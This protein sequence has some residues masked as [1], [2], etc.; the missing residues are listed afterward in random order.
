MRVKIVLLTNLDKIRLSP[1]NRDQVILTTSQPVYTSFQPM[2]KFLV[3]NGF[4]KR[5]LQTFA[6]TL[7]ILKINYKV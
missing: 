5:M 1:F 3:K 4:Q 7:E 2:Q 6:Q